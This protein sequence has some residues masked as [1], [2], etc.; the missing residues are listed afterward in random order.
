MTHGIGKSV[1]H[2][3]GNLSIHDRKLM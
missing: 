1:T 2:D 3:V